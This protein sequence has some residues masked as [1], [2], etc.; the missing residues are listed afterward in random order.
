M[1][2]NTNILTA[3]SMG[4]ELERYEVKEP[5]RIMKKAIQLKTSIVI[6]EI[7]ATLHWIYNGDNEWDFFE[8][9]STDVNNYLFQ[10]MK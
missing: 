4:K 3:E 6:P 2:I 5:L 1:R 9:Y 10:L 7:K 8:N